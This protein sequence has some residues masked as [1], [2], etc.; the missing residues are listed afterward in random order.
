MDSKSPTL[1]EYILSPLQSSI[2]WTILCP[3]ANPNVVFLKMSESPNLHFRYNINLFYN[4]YCKSASYAS[5]PNLALFPGI[6]KPVIK[7]DRISSI[8]LLGW[9]SITSRFRGDTGGI[10][11]A[12]NTS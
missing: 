12:G 9:L 7:L 6:R 5:P 11:I 3:W 4:C 1:P 2:S 8:V 10:P